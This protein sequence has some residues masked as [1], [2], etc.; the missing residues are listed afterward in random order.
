MK[1]PLA[2]N[3]EG[4]SNN[5]MHGWEDCEARVIFAGEDCGAPKRKQRRKEKINKEK[6]RNNY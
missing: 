5:R 2:K 1:P 4:V 3:S 6:K